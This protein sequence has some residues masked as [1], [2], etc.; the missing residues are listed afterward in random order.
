MLYS[1][2]EGCGYAYGFPVWFLLFY[3]MYSTLLTYLKD[4][5]NMTSHNYPE[6]MHR[7]FIVN[8]PGIFSS[9]WSLAKPVLHPRTVKKVVICT[10]D[11]L[12]SLLT[13]IPIQNLPVDFCIVDYD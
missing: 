1:R 7:S 2:Y 12:E 6:T 3:I 13:E 9:L 4:M 10:G 8:V 5:T 11:Y